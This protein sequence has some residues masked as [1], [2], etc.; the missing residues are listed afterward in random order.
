MVISMMTKM[1]TSKVDKGG[2]GEDGHKD[3]DQEKAQLL[4]H[5]HHLVFVTLED[6]SRTETDG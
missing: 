1:V 5:H 2:V 3:Q 6:N 4:H